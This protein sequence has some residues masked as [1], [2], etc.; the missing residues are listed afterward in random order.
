MC[1][2]MTA[3]QESALTAQNSKHFYT[4]MLDAIFGEPRQKHGNAPIDPLDRML[5]GVDDSIARLASVRATHDVRAGA[6]HTSAELLAP[7]DQP[8]WRETMVR[9]EDAHRQVQRAAHEEIVRL[10]ALPIYKLRDQL[11]ELSELGIPAEAVTWLYLSGGESLTVWVTREGFK[12]SR[13]S[14][15]PE[16]VKAFEIGA[17]P[18]PDLAGVEVIVGYTT[19]TGIRVTCDSQNNGSHTCP[20]DSPLVA[21]LDAAEGRS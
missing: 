7:S 4:E 16:D 15:V 17:H 20:P 13:K 21:E 12:A 10:R 9:L 2:K 6:A 5:R 8:V 11:D 14:L 1:Q 3:A 18:N 19:T